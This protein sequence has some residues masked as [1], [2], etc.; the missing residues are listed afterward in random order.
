[1]THSSTVDISSD[2]I[3][4]WMN[5]IR[6]LSNNKHQ[7]TLLEN[8]WGDQIRSKSWLTNELKKLNI[9]VISN[10]FIFGGWYGLLA[11]LLSD[12]YFHANIFSIDI[13]PLCKEY[14]E[15]LRLPN[16][17]IQFLTYD[18][19]YFAYNTFPDIVINTST[20]HIEQ[21]TFD[22]WKSK[23]PKNTL[24]V[25]QGNNFYSCE[26]H[27]RCASSLENFNKIN[28]LK[29]I[30]YSNELPCY[31]YNRYMTIGTAS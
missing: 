31:G 6:D 5:I 28:P 3:I 26:G 7:S 20:E 2:R 29:K 9:P 21:K 16:D 19:Q 4:V 12:S 17:K 22:E 27:V 13:D 15:K 24:V 14:G 10:I 18:M 30:I 25:L 1:M 23:I 11:Q 8:F